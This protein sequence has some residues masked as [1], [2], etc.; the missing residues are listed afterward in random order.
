VFWVTSWCNRASW[1]FLPFFRLCLPPTTKTNSSGFQSSFEGYQY[2]GVPHDLKNKILSR[3]CFCSSSERTHSQNIFLFAGIQ[4]NLNVTYTKKSKQEATFIIMIGS[5]AWFALMRR[6]V[7]YRKRNWIGTVRRLLISYLLS[8]LLSS[9]CDV[10]DRINERANQQLT[11]K[12]SALHDGVRLYLSFSVSWHCSFSR[13]DTLSVSFELC[14][15]LTRYFLTNDILT[16]YFAAPRVR[17][18]HCL[19]RHFGGD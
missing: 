4:F 15:I 9:Q 7:V 18:T 8:L 3:L 10:G 17:L 6:N 14:R 11:S 16:Y 19:S 1:L 5:R 13:Y 2:P 12:S